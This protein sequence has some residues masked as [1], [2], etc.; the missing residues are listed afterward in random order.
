MYLTTKEAD[1]LLAD[2]ERLDPK[3]AEK[4]RD[5]FTAAA[6]LRRNTPEHP[7]GG[8]AKPGLWRRI[9]AR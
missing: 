1:D 4:W 2:L 9:F 3:V 8:P 7:K 6:W 5:V